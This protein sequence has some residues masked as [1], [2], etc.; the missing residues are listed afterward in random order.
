VALLDVDAVSLVNFYARNHPQQ[1]TVRG[2]DGHVD[3]RWTP[4]DLYARLDARFGFTLD[5]AA[6]DVNHKCAR[7][8]TYETNGLAQPW[9]GIVWCNPPYSDIRSWVSKAWGAMWVEGAWVVVML[10]PANRTEQR[11]WQDFIEPVRDRGPID[12]VSLR[13]EFLSGRLRFGRPGWIPGP[14]GDRP[15]FGCCLLIWTRT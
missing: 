3:D 11:W 10:V 2:A 15:P 13:V 4:D 14:K 9:E 7:Y 8:Y 5:A 12:G 1:V 6:S